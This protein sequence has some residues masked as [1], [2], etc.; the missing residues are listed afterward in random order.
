MILHLC[1]RG[2]RLIAGGFGEGGIHRSIEADPDSGVPPIHPMAD[3]PLTDFMTC[4]KRAQPSCE[5]AY[6]EYSG[7]DRKGHQTFNL[8]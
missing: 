4:R 7:S 3:M 6:A 2:R 8:V 5:A 1:D